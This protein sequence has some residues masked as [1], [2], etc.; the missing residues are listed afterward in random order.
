MDSR[1]G[2]EYVNGSFRTHGN[3]PAHALKG[4]VRQ[5][6]LKPNRVEMLKSIYK[7]SKQ[8]KSLAPNSSEFEGF[9]NGGTLDLQLNGSSYQQREAVLK[10]KPVGASNKHGLKQG[11]QQAI[12]QLMPSQSQRYEHQLNMIKKARAAENSSRNNNNNNI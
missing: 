12:N 7:A 1:E 5:L 11:I 9:T 2:G 6:K 4:T 10:Y 3:S 8:P